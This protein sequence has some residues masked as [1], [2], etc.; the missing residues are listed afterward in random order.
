MLNPP[1]KNRQKIFLRS[2]RPVLGILASKIKHLAKNN[3]WNLHSSLR[4][5]N[6]KYRLSVQNVFRDPIEF[7]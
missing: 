2:R 3:F 1:V 4:H 7:N 5:P 6:V